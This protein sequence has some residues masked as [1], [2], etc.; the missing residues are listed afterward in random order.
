MSLLRDFSGVV[1]WR[2]GVRRE[3]GFCQRHDHWADLS[4]AELDI[5]L[6]LQ[7]LPFSE[8]NPFFLQPWSP[9]L[10]AV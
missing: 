1:F 10:E 9:N 7:C 2:V 6:V 5:R 3:A 4:M 8:G